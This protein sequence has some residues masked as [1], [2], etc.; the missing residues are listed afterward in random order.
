ML[1][2]LS[3]SY[4]GCLGWLFDMKKVQQTSPLMDEYQ[5]DDDDFCS[6]VTLETTS[7]NTLHSN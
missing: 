7:K 2:I 3:L 5:I 1:L 6:Y 4:R